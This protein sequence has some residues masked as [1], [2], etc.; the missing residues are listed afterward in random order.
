M[1]FAVNVGRVLGVIPDSVFCMLTLMAIITTLIN[2]PLVLRLIRGTEL[3]P[4]I[5]KSGFV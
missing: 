5:R 3:E 1:L 2:T 4:H